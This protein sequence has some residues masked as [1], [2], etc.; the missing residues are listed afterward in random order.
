MAEDWITIKEAAEV[1][2]YAADY[3][4]DLAREGK[5]AARKIATVW[6]VSRKNLLAHMRA[7]NKLGEKRGPK[8]KKVGD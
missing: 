2:G 7:A 6:L 1:T 5:I 3:I 8:K 4:R